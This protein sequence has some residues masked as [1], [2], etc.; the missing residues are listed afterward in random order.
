M[1]LTRYTAAGLTPPVKLG[2]STQLFPFNSKHYF[3]RSGIKLEHF[4][5]CTLLRNPCQ[6]YFWKLESRLL[7]VEKPPSFGSRHFSLNELNPLKKMKQISLLTLMSNVIQLCNTCVCFLFLL[8]GWWYIQ[9]MRIRRSS[10]ISCLQDVECFGDDTCY[11]T[12]CTPSYWLDSQPIGTQRLS[13]ISSLQDVECFGDD[14]CYSPPTVL[15][16]YSQPIGA[17][18]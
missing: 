9:P 12:E 10:R 2:I 3:L 17:R 16:R 11:C 14:T 15:A 13:W 18:R 4:L 1:S 5:K 6:P 7:L 8:D